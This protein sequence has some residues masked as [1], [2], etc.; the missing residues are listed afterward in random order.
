MNSDD[1]DAPTDAIRADVPEDKP[2]FVERRRPGRLNYTNQ[3]LIALLRRPDGDVSKEDISPARG[4]I[5]GLKGDMA[6]LDYANCGINDVIKH[7]LRLHPQ[8]LVD[9]LRSHARVHAEFADAYDN[10]EVT[11]SELDLADRLYAFANAVELG[12]HTIPDELDVRHKAFSCAAWL[13]DLH[14]IMQRAI[15]ER[16]DARSARPG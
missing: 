10:R 5:I 12:D 7:S 6:A 1:C 2:A 13:Q 8:L 3:A 9:R 15:A 4:V 14:P 11:R 16:D